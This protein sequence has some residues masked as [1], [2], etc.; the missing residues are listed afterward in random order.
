MNAAQYYIG[1]IIG[2]QEGIPTPLQIDD[3][4]F[5][6]TGIAVVTLMLIASLWVLIRGGYGEISRSLAFVG[7]LITLVLLVALLWALF[8]NWIGWL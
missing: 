8:V 2:L 5:E 4:A 3:T 6:W 1:V 7:V